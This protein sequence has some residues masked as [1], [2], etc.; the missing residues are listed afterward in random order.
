[1]ASTKDAELTE[2]KE[3]TMAQSNSMSEEAR[4]KRHN[5]S[6]GFGTGH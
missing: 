3:K 1:M 4:T 6:G 2:T 5:Y